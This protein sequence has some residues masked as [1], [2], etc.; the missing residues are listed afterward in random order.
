MDRMHSLRSVLVA[1]SFLFSFESPGARGGSLPDQAPPLPV[2][3]LSGVAFLTADFAPL[4]RFYGQGAGPSPTS[5]AVLADVINIAQN[6]TA[7]RDNAPRFIPE[8]KSGIK[9]M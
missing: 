1:A 4:R 5:S 3:G 9:P 7:G 6:I 2:S 8:K